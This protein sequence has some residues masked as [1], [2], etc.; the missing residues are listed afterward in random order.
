M[1]YI[2]EFTLMVSLST[3]MQRKTR[4]STIKNNTKKQHCKPQKKL[5]I[6][7]QGPTNT[8]L[9]NKI[10][11]TKTNDRPVMTKPKDKYQDDSDDQLSI[12]I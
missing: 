1:L 5:G 10:S 3:E 4:T 12:K 8:E 6:K 9:S 7:G 11:C 2:L